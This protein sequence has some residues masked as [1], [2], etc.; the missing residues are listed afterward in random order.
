MTHPTQTTTA[1]E[2]PAFTPYIPP[3]GMADGEPTPEAV[4]A[5]NTYWTAWQAE[6]AERDAARAAI[7]RANPEPPLAWVPPAA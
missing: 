3:M 1:T 6:Q 5:W 2:T 4:A 7:L